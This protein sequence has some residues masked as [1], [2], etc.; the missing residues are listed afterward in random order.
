MAPLEFEDGALRLEP[1]DQD[2]A[3]GYLRA[4]L[5]D[6]DTFRWF[7]EIPRSHDMPGVLEY[8]DRRTRDGY[9]A[10]A[11]LVEGVFVGSSSFFDVRPADFAVE[12]GHTWFTKDFRGTA[13]NPRVKSAMMGHAVD[14]CGAIRVQLKTDARNLASQ[15]AME[16]IGLV[17][18]GTL[19]HNIIMP[20]GAFRDTVYYSMIR[21]EWP[22]MKE[23]LAGQAEMKEPIESALARFLSK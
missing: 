19:R 18:E 17:R 16:K 7:T 1:L 23:R 2:H 21:D 11:I 6:P 12:I 8:I 4:L 15:R 13:L 20:D 9:H 3:A 22:A 14:Q 5:P 10:L